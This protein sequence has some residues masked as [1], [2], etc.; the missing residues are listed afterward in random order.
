MA[1]L[2]AEYNL[3]KYS[4]L[5]N[6]R[7]RNKLALCIILQVSNIKSVAVRQQKNKAHRRNKDR[8][9]AFFGID[10][11]GVVVL[12]QGDRAALLRFGSDVSDDEPCGVFRPDPSHLKRGGERRRRR[13]VSGRHEHCILG[14]KH[15]R[16]MEGDTSMV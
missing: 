12:Q 8:D 14:E 6:Q 13:R 11:D 5:Y 10:H 4:A 9:G 16:G 2:S 7:R 3:L 15:T 1:F